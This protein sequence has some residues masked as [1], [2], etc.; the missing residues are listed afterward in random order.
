M[1]IPYYTELEPI[2]YRQYGRNVQ[3]MVEHLRAVEDPEKRKVLARVTL[4]AM[5][6]VVPEDHERA[7]ADQ[8]LWENLY[9]IAGEDLHLDPPVPLRDRSAPNEA[10]GWVAYQR[11]PKGEKAG[12]TRQYGRLVSR[13]IEK[14][15]EMPE[16]EA[17]DQYILDIARIMKLQLQEQNAAGANDA[18]VCRHLAELSD[19]KIDLDPTD[20]DITLGHLPNRVSN[21]SFTDLER[22]ASRKKKQKGKSQPPNQAPQGQRPAGRKKR[23]NRGK[24]FFNKGGGGQN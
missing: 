4:T 23:R 1:N 6:N 24:R 9:N 8:L 2:R 13:M 17:Q 22:K 10:K 20:T 14:A 5:R 7:D 3:Q 19:G 15:L 16:G 11:R 18:T 21:K 12:K